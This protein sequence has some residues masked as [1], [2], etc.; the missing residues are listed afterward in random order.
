[1]KK[2]SKLSTFIALL[3][4]LV[5]TI[6]AFRMILDISGAFQVEKSPDLSF[7][8]NNLLFGK[9]K[10]ILSIIALLGLIISLTL[11]SILIK[12]FKSE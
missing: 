12:K 6:G 7:I 1:M 2:A 10:I 4:S 11:T 5:M 8:W 3:F 9:A